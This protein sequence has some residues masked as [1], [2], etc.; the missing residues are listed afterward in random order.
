MLPAQSRANP[1]LALSGSEGIA[2]TP[3]LLPSLLLATV[4]F[5]MAFVYSVVTRVQQMPS[6][7]RSLNPL[8]PVHAERAGQ[9]GDGSSDVEP[10]PNSEVSTSRSSVISVS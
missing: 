9:R 3:A 6:R 4:L 8:P 7:L 2:R 10:A 5:G 1:V